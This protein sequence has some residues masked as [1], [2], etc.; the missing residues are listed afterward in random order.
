VQKSYC[1]I[2]LVKN[3]IHGTLKKGRC[4]RNKWPGRK[5]RM[6]ETRLERKKEGGE[7]SLQNEGHRRYQGKHIFPFM[8]RGKKKRREHWDVAKGGDLKTYRFRRWRNRGRVKRVRGEKGLTMS[9]KEKARSAQ[10]NEKGRRT[11]VKQLG[12][13]KNKSSGCQTLGEWAAR[14]YI[15]RNGF[16][17]SKRGEIRHGE[18]RLGGPHMGGRPQQHS[19]M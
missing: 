9:G 6:R 13:R 3:S 11:G 10:H 18:A 8:K 17:G 1:A 12:K 4:E 5:N 19:E 15:H 16:I 14:N 2:N 7:I